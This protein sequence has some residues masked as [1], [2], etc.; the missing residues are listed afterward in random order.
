MA[1]A[2]Q[3]RGGLQS[4]VAGFNAGNGTGW[5]A[6]PYSGTIQV[7][8]N[9]FPT[10]INSGEGRILK[11][12]EFSNV[13]VPG[14]WLFRVDE[15]II[16]GGCSNESIG[17]MTTAPIAASMIGGVLVNVSGP[18]L[19]GGDVVKVIFEYVRASALHYKQYVCSSQFSEYQ[20]DCIRVII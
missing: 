7:H 1:G 15:E 2:L 11:L 3:G 10:L 19:R 12:Q 17:Y 20:V 18:C 4:A 6:L 9:L 5:T 14:R 16:N 13:G 8:T